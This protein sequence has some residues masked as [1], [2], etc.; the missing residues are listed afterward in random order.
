MNKKGNIAMVTMFKKN[1][2]SLNLREIDTE[3]ITTLAR[4]IRGV[5]MVLFYKEI[6][7]NTFRVS[8]RSKGG[9]NAAFIAEHF[10]GGGHLHAAGFTVTGKYDS[11]LR[12]ITETVD[13]L[14]KKQAKIKTNN[15][16]KSID[17][18]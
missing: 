14:L 3:D 7:E 4:S 8:L 9:A 10:G 12:E 1:L 13:K 2:D 6:K 18:Y 5:E 17:S 16:Q 15:D 11:L